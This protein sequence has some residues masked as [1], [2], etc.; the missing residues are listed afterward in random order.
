MSLL[1]VKNVAKQFGGLKALMDFSMEVPESH[2]V[3]I[4]GPNGAGKTTLFNVVSGSLGADRGSVVFQG[5]EI[6][7]M[8]PDQICGLG[9][10]R[11]FQITKP[12]AEMT[13]V[14][15]TMIGSFLRHSHHREARDKALEV[16]D[17]IGLSAQRGKKASDLTVSDGK[18]LEIARALA[19]GPKLILLDEVFAGLNPTGSEQLMGLVREIN[20]NGVT[21][22]MI[23]HVMQAV[24][25]LSQ[26][27]V[28]L[29]YGVK[30]TEGTPED[31][32][33]NEDVIQAYLGKAY[34]RDSVD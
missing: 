12:L 27:I 6:Q 24:M 21:V 16:L 14:E 5:R 34:A 13:V 20:E 17:F 31:V 22:V 30:L 7:G 1:E 11:T 29:N 33:T 19:T 3:G 9:I 32:V 8:R 23:E 15:N 26:H 28:V 4:I 2:I 25:S 18:R 10:A